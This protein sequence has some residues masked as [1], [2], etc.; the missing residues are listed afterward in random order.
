MLRNQTFKQQEAQK[1]LN[2]S[3]SFV[4][5]NAELLGVEKIKVL[6]WNYRYHIKYAQYSHQDMFRKL[7]EVTGIY[8]FLAGYQAHTL[9]LVA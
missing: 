3:K 2:H 7:K 4:E 5:Q 8:L 9:D 1:D 6:P